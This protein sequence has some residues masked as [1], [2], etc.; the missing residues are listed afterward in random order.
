MKALVLSFLEPDGQGRGIIMG[1]PRLHTVTFFVPFLSE[2]VEAKWGQWNKNFT[3][4]WVRKRHLLDSL[5]LFGKNGL[6]FFFF[7][8]KTFLF[9]KIQSWNFQQLFEIEFRETSQN[10]KAIRQKIEKNWNKNCLNEL[11]ELKFCEVSRN[12]ISNSCWKFQLSILKNKKVLFLK[13]I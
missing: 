2:V 13:N 1:A 6:N 9:F 8:N 7:R 10:F 5:G 11:N 3:E 12:S 4:N